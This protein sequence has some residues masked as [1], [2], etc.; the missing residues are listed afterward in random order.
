[1]I[2]IIIDEKIHN[3]Q[4]AKG[5]KIDVKYITTFNQKKVSKVF[6]DDFTEQEMV[7]MKQFYDKVVYENEVGN[8]VYRCNNDGNAI[9]LSAYK[10]IAPTETGIEHFTDDKQ[11]T[12]KFTRHGLRD[13]IVNVSLGYNEDFTQENLD[14]L[15]EIGIEVSGKANNFGLIGYNSDIS[16]QLVTGK[17]N[18]VISL[19]DFENGVLIFKKE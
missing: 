14:D 7:I 6:P 4:L 13:E 11:I 9:T 18:S 8:N 12:W 2:Q 3:E 5:K 19:G 1:M 15:V 17:D 16:I 10:R